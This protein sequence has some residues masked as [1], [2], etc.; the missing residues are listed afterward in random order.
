[1]D[2]N[3]TPESQPQCGTYVIEVAHSHG[4]GCWCSYHFAFGVDRRRETEPRGVD[5]RL[6]HCDLRG[7]N[8]GLLAIPR[9][10]SERLLHLRIPGNSNVTFDVSAR[11]ASR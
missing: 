8:V 6:A 9:D 7:M 10:S 1:M 4:I 3:L 5:Q 2:N 11:L